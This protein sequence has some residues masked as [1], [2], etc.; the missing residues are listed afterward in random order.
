MWARG[1]ISSSVEGRGQFP[2]QLSAVTKI[3]DQ[4]SI[5]HLL[6]SFSWEVYVY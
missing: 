6:E 5:G 1:L 3:A 4:K 2:S